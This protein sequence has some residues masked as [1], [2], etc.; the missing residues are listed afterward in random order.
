MRPV[1]PRS[2]CAWALIASLAAVACSTKEGPPAVTQG[3]TTGEG[4][5]IGF[6]FESAPRTSGENVFEVTVTKDGAPVTGAAVT[7]VFSMPAMPS[8]NMPEMRSTAALAPAGNG[9][10]RGAGQLSMAG[11]WNVRVT[12][13]HDSRELGTRTLSVVAK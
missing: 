3:T 4:V 12:V 13:V 8:M 5:D 7:A 11:T 6:R 1:S 2:T 9:R 10:Y